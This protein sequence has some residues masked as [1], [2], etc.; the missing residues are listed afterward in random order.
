MACHYSK[1]FIQQVGVLILSS[2]FFLSKQYFEN[3]VIWCNTKVLFE[4][5]DALSKRCFFHSLLQ[6]I[7]LLWPHFRF[8]I[9]DEKDPSLISKACKPDSVR[10]KWIFIQNN[11]RTSAPPILF[12]FSP[13][14]V[15]SNCS[16]YTSIWY[17]KS[18]ENFNF[19]IKALYA[20]RESDVQV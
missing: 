6:S 20:G 2:N 14:Y 9:S 1:I 11:Q 12:F 16:M 3:S 15:N 7:L 10:P 13:M 17:F 18:D 4:K 19:H 8:Q 5:K